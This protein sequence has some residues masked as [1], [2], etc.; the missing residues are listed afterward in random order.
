[1]SYQYVLHQSAQ[2]DYEEALQWYIERS[3]RA[4]KTL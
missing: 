1:M 3:E 4:Q 2:K